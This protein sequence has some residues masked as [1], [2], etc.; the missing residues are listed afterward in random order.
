MSGKYSLE[1]LEPRVMLSADG[2]AGGLITH[3]PAYDPADLGAIE[4]VQ[5]FV[6]SSAQKA[7][8]FSSASDS[9]ANLDDLFEGKVPWIDV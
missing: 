8:E 3:D 7:P 9:V 6:G 1:L 5:E 2:M 4:V